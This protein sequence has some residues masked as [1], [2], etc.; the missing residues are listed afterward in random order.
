MDSN[1]KY[2]SGIGFVDLLFNVLI[3]FVFLFLIA[4]LLINPVAKRADVVSPAQFL[5][6]MSWPNGDVNDF[7]LWVRDPLNNYIG[8]H[9][10]DVGIT[11][12]DRDD[13]GSLN[14]HVYSNEKEKIVVSV[15][16]E[17]ISIRGIL[18]GEYIVS[19][20]L[21]RVQDDSQKAGVPVTVE[22]EKINP[23]SI[24]FNR[25]HMIREMGSVTNFLRFVVD[26]DGTVIEITET[27]ESAVPY[28]VI[29]TNQPP[30]PPL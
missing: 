19:V 22:L 21:Y 3:G 10:K 8:F 1:D 2:K 7:D 28:H 12:L 29:N 26:E 4:F 17:V 15:N 11:N 13:L 30:R 6:I 16:R 5:V 9:S 14:D 27:T 24:L 20:H 18:P 23:F 25:T